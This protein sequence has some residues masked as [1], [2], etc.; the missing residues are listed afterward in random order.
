M[1]GALDD[2]RLPVVTTSWDDGHPLDLRLAER[3]AAAGLRGTFYVPL[4]TGERRVMDRSAVLA[5]RRMGMEIGSHTVTHRVLTRLAPDAA[6]VELARS[7]EVLEQW[8]G[9]PVE[10]F[11]YPRGVFNRRVR[12]QVARA[13][14]RLARTTRSFLDR[15]MADPFRMPV[16]FQFFPHPAAIH[17]RHALKEGNLMGLAHWIRD[18]RG[19]TALGALVETSVARVLERGG[20]LHLWGH[21]WEMEEFGLWEALASTCRALG[22]ARGL[23]PATNSEALALATAAAASAG[24]PAGARAPAAAPGPAR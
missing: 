9:E 2:R 17:V 8:L 16:S 15:E 1:G 7:K 20:T 19:A 6:R 4:R 18:H 21:S 3:L 12:A 5:L 10:A 14:Y 24:S 22:G 13:G 23:R 11:S